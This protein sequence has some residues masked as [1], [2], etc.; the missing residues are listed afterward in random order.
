LATPRRLAAAIVAAV[1]AAVLSGVV[2]VARA[3]RRPPPGPPGETRE[4]PE[5]RETRETRETTSIAEPALDATNRARPALEATSRAARSTRLARLGTR[6]GRHYV[7]SSARAVFASAERR[8]VLRAERRLRTTE[9][10]VAELGSMKGA[11]MK[12]GQMA[13][14]LDTG[15]APE[16]R[17]SLASLQADAPPMSAELAGSVIESELGVPPERLFA[18]WDPV[19]I[20]AASIGQVHRAITVEG[21][22]V[23]VKVQYP[24]VAEAIDG[25]LANTGALVQL[26]RLAFPGLDAE[27]VVAELRSRVVEE[28]DYR[29]EARN[30]TAFAERFAG[31]P[32]IHIPAVIPELSKA[33]VLTSELVVG[34][35][36]QEAV[37]W[38]QAE[39]DLA[40]ETIYRFVFGSL[41]RL[42]VFNGDP[43]PG[44]YLFHGGGRVTF[45][46][47]GL[48]KWFTD[49]D[50]QLL[51]RMVQAA[52]TTPDDHKFRR[53]VE[54]AGF[55]RPDPELTDEQVADYFR[56]YYKLV[57]HQ[58]P[59]RMT[60]DYADETVRHFFDAGNPVLKRANV[61]APF[62]IVQRIN[63]GLYAV[64]AGLRATADWRRIADELWPWVNAGPSTDLGR[65]EAAWRAGRTPT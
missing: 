12:L 56:H 9:E 28:L 25:D 44:N 11:M 13:S 43:H 19:P 10:V 37:R 20:A 47:F 14:Y 55:L 33:K 48:V 62:V 42:R 23:A 41:Y 17:Q 49:R 54:E 5:T 21:Q 30:Q 53:A 1:V 8:D 15:L 65:A 32:H 2:V 61:P 59:M 45:L 4:T 64:L 58:G 57:I 40:G 6:V 52:V 27:P 29:L 35:R 39:R 16:V 31:H 46:D 7:S 34:A 24:G 22:A 51:T 63:L 50:V 36:Y 60:Q 18:E 26:V 38:N 3:L